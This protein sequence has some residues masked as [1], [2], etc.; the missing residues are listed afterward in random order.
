MR[1]DSWSSFSGDDYDYD[2]DR[3]LSDY[4]SPEDSSSSISFMEDDSSDEIIDKPS[5][6]IISNLR[7]MQNAQQTQKVVRAGDKQPRRYTKNAQGKFTGSISREALAKEAAR[8]NRKRYGDI[9]ILKVTPAA[10]PD[11][12][13]K[14]YTATTSESTPKVVAVDPIL[15]SQEIMDII[16]LENVTNDAPK[17]KL[18]TSEPHP[19]IFRRTKDVANLKDTIQRGLLNV[20]YEGKDLELKQQNSDRWFSVQSCEW[21]LIKRRG[22][23][24]LEVNANKI[25]T[26]SYKKWNAYLTAVRLQ[27][28]LYFRD[29]LEKGVE[30]DRLQKIR[31]S[32][33]FSGGDLA[34]RLNLSTTDIVKIG[35][36]LQRYSEYYALHL[37]NNK[38]YPIYTLDAL[39][40]SADEII[41]FLYN[42]TRIS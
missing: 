17:Q 38:N 39:G 25:I 4:S 24:K 2:L 23:S 22:F 32:D 35:E 28:M 16:N 42:R 34:T 37:L 26:G 8:P 19:P 41:I 10:L 14:P 18:F 30:A 21:H 15:D 7:K 29:F 31:R 40:K 9:P 36:M 33:I 12:S 6:G 27:Y 11:L 13:P 20:V 3:E 5:G 1:G